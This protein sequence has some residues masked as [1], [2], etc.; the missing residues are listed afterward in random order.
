MYQ[1]VCTSLN[2]LHAMKLRDDLVAND[3]SRDDY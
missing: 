1:E 2:L 3:I